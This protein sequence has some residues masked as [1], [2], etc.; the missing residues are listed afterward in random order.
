MTL[1]DKEAEVNT[2]PYFATGFLPELPPLTCEASDEIW[3]YQLPEVKDEEAHPYEVELLLPEALEEYLRLDSS[4]MI[5]QSVE[6]QK[7]KMLTRS[8]DTTQD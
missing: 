8:N 4:K 6:G 1:F 7:I 3:E 5:I 2:P